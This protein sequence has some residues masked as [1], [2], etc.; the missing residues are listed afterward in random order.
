MWILSQKLES[1][2]ILWNPQENITCLE[3]QQFYVIFNRLFFVSQFFC[4]LYRFSNFFLDENFDS[5]INIPSLCE[6][7]GMSPGA[8]PSFLQSSPCKCSCQ[9]IV[10]FITAPRSFSLLLSVTLTLIHLYLSYPFLLTLIA[11]FCKLSV[12]HSTHALTHS[13][14]LAYTINH[15]LLLS[16]TLTL[17]HP[18]LLTLTATFCK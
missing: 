9:V 13:H 4:H 1:E 10:L 18:F 8:F 7:C 2:N 11:T 16:V 5:L 17:T 14:S 12:R 6:S 3:W 15:S